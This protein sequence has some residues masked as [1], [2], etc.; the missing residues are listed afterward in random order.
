[1]VEY[2]KLPSA[3]LLIANLLVEYI[4]YACFQRVVQH[5]S[6]QYVSCIVQINMKTQWVSESPYQNVFDD[7]EQVHHQMEEHSLRSAMQDIGY[8]EI[9]ELEYKL[10]GDKRLVQIDFISDHSQ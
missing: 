6:P 5:V 4:G 2:Q 10:S 3:Q 8:H 7:L 1:M 9:R